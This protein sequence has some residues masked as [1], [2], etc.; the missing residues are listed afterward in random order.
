MSNNTGMYICSLRKKKGMT[1][2]QLADKL[3]VSHQAVSKW[4]RGN[5][6]PDTSILPALANALSCSVDDILNGESL[7]SPRV[8]EDEPQLSSPA[9]VYPLVLT[10]YLF[11]FASAVGMFTSVNT[12]P[13]LWIS[14]GLVGGTLILIKNISFT[15]GAYQSHIFLTDA[16][17]M[18]AVIAL[19]IILPAYLG[20]IKQL[21][22]ATAGGVYTTVT[23]RKYYVES[24]LTS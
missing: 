13:L 23:C 5:G 17:A 15:Q 20:L 12:P 11:V 2:V 3:N 22:M 18:L 19:G 21:L 10:S 1:Q 14:M 8:I 16:L 7:P 24:D 6:L 9:R 4:E